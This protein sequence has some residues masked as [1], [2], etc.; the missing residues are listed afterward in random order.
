V[1]QK[2]AGGAKDLVRV[3][4]QL[5]IKGYKPLISGIS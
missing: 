5:K 1:T 4:D 3:V 2:P